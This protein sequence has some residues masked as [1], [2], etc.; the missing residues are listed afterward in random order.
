MYSTQL[1]KISNF[2]ESSI[3]RS[4]ESSDIV[5]G[6]VWFLLLFVYCFLSQ[7]SKALQ[8]LR[9]ARPALHDILFQGSSFSPPIF[10]PL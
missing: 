5:I 8:E 3:T 6:I 2:I 9:T 1:F 4:S 10:F 7:S